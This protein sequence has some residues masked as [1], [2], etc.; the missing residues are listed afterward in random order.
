VIMMVHIVDVD[1]GRHLLLLLLLLFIRIRRWQKQGLVEQCS[2]FFLCWR[3][4]KLDTTLMPLD[5]GHFLLFNRLL[6]P[7]LSYVHLSFTFG[8][9][10]EVCGMRAHTLFSSVIFMRTK[11][12]I[13]YYF[14]KLTCW[15][16]I[17]LLSASLLL[18][19]FPP[20]ITF[21]FVQAQ[22]WC[23]WCNPAA[24]DWLGIHVDV[25]CTMY[26]MYKSRKKI[27][28]NHIF[29]QYSSTYCFSVFN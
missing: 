11:K 16:R 6:S 8:R 2:H 29:L 10:Q 5:F 23:W 17:K 1:D 27:K 20:L 12:Y 19:Q 3:M 14:I 4:I 25:L 24:K 22:H 18:V 28:W 26:V 9:G 13:F 15:L 21:P 7:L